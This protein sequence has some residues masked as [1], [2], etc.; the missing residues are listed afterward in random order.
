V[1]QEFR[2]EIRI[3]DPAVAFITT[4]NPGAYTAVE[5]LM[6]RRRDRCTSAATPSRRARA[7]SG[8]ALLVSAK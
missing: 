2:A 8:D 1:L 5:L 3:A 6:A 7:R 4:I